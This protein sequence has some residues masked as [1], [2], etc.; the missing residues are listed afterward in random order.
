MAVCSHVLPCISVYSY[1]CRFLS[2]CLYWIKSNHYMT[3]TPRTYREES[4]DF[5]IAEQRSV[6]SRF[7]EENNFKVTHKTVNM[8][9]LHLKNEVS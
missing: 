1:V 8:D 7:L 4:F 6:S 5:A 3:V 9:H 2:L